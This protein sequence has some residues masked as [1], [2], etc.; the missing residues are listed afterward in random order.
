MCWL[1]AKL[2]TCPELG[3]VVEEVV[4]GHARVEALEVLLG[5][6]ERLVDAFLD[7][8]RR[9]HDHELGEAEA[10]VQLEDR[11]QVDVGLAR[12]GLHLHGEVSW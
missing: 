6:L 8:D 3:R 2:R 5:D 1:V 4:E 12:A 7:G 11:P 10:L 9:H